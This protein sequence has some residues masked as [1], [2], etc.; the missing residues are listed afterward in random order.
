ML[1]RSSGRIAAKIKGEGLVNDTISK[2]MSVIKTFM[3]WAQSM[4]YH[5]NE[6]TKILKQRKK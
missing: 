3:K 6:A 1:K 2:Y 4:K 5:S